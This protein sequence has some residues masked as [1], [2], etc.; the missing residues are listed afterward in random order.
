MDDTHWRARW[1]TPPPPHAPPID[2]I[3]TATSH[4]S[5]T[6]AVDARPSSETTSSRTSSRI[7]RQPE[8]SDRPRTVRR[9]VREA[10]PAMEDPLADRDA[11][12]PRRRATALQD[13][14]AGC[15][16]RATS[17]TAQQLR[18]STANL[19][20]PPPSSPP[21]DATIAR[22]GLDA[23]PRSRR[24][25]ARACPRPTA[26]APAR[27]DTQNRSHEGSLGGCE[28]KATPIAIPVSQ[29]MLSRL[30]ARASELA[31]RVSNYLVPRLFPVSYLD[32]CCFRLMC[33]FAATT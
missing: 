5:P 31:M 6:A 16:P 7:S 18:R 13:Y 21:S 33:L 14:R 19:R 30:S 24:A 11:R 26:K 20:D 27:G 15:S 28:A 17:P 3:R 2:M 25:Y 1:P 22:S 29:S 9:H 8:T 32:S 4:E 12:T 10:N 23:D